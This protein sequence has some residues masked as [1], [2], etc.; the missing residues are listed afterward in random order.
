MSKSV[1]FVDLTQESNKRKI[2]VIDLDTDQDSESSYY[3][4]SEEDDVVIVEPDNK[5]MVC[6]GMV[7][8]I[9]RN[10]QTET[11]NKEFES[12]AKE[13]PVILAPYIDKIT[14]F[15][16]FDTRQNLLGDLEFSMSSL[17]AP[18]MGLGIEFH[19][20]LPKVHFNVN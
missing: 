3:R 4:S 7:E 15:K 1:Q 5:E 19:A 20:F 12:G 17:L 8:S 18:L 6:F 14:K 11:I 10:G 13:I 9:I 16:V 2:D